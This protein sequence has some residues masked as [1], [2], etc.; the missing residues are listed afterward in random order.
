MAVD[1]TESVSSHIILFKILCLWP[2]GNPKLYK[3]YTLFVLVLQVAYNILEICH[4]FV[5]SATI[6]EIARTSITIIVNTTVFTKQIILLNNLPLLQKVFGQLVTQEFFQSRNKNEELIL[7]RGVRFS[8]RYFQIVGGLLVVAVI[9]YMKITILNVSTVISP[10]KW[11][12]YDVLPPF[13]GNY[14]LIPFWFLFGELYTGMMIVGF[15]TVFPILMQ[16]FCTQCELL[17]HRISNLDK[18]QFEDDL[19]N[20]L[21]FCIQ[22]YDAILR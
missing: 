4:V 13:F 3:M 22:H 6:F 17:C 9:I 8:R 18:N 21:R 19:K 20:E 16:Q 7:K 15:D 2:D 12:W 11:F 10:S 5:T 14:V 1:L